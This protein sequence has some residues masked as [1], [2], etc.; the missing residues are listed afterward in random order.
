MSRM[1][2]D[3]FQPIFHNHYLTLKLN[4]TSM[5]KNYLNDFKNDSSEKIDCLKI[6]CL[7]R[8]K[9]KKDFHPIC[10][11]RLNF[12][13]KIFNLKEVPLT[14]LS[15][16]S[17]CLL[18]LTTASDIISLD[19]NEIFLVD[20]KF[21]FTYKWSNFI[22]E[23]LMSWSQWPLTI[24]CLISRFKNL[25]KNE[26]QSSELHFD[27][28]Q[29]F[30]VDTLVHST[31]QELFIREQ[32]AV[33]YWLDLQNK[34]SI[35]KRFFDKNNNSVKTRRLAPFEL[36]KNTR[37]CSQ[38]FQ[39]W[40]LNYQ[41]WHEKISLAISNRSMTFEEQFQRILEL[42]VRFLIYEKHPTGIADQLTHLISTYFVALLTNRLFI[43][44]TNWPEFINTMQSSLNYQPEFIIPWYSQFDLIKKNL[45]LTIQNNLTI[46]AH[47]FSLDRYNRDFNYE[48]YLRQRIAILKGH[49]G[50][51]IHTITSNLSIY[52]KF[53]TI[54]LEMNSENIFGCLYHSLFTY[55]L[56]SL[57]KSIPLI[58]SN[59]QL[60]HSSQQILQILLSPRFFSIGIQIRAGDQTLTRANSVFDEE[61]IK[62]F[63][64]YFICSQQ[65]INTNKKLFRDTNQIPI[66]FLL[67]DSVQIRQ[68]ALKRWKFSLECF[69][70][71]ENQCQSNNNDSKILSHSDP[72]FHI[73]MTSNQKLAFQLG[74]FDQFL[75]SLCEQHIITLKSGFGRIPAFASLKLR[76]IYSLESKQE[77]FCENQS[78]PL[79]IS[80]HHWSGI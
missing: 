26:N 67:S 14:L 27:S 54:D 13:I 73:A 61:I 31:S 47:W 58:S 8:S 45:S 74:I 16:N 57:I 72:V 22:E 40:I 20:D 1:E 5:G 64:N 38:K 52:R 51:V 19:I 50:G 7:K 68:A 25:P 71:V 21:R 60:G 4:L 69:Q 28:F 43:F 11:I 33:S 29:C 34:E 2:E 63:E 48:D 37:V 76:N 23:K 70:S 30:S 44:D 24:T 41:Q 32:E 79:A 75:F 65:I 36:A 17:S 39:N 18:S 78:V 49:T 15:K 46:G 62:R 12:R 9:N 42:N 55:R 56:S 77:P 35:D 53:L 59:N 10:H 80:G 3:L 6:T 66:I